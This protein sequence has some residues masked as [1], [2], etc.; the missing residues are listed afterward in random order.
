MPI[1]LETPTIRWSEAE[2]KALEAQEGD[3]W[4]NWAE[5]LK[6]QLRAYPR[7]RKLGALQRETTLA[8]EGRSI[9]FATEDR[10]AVYCIRCYGYPKPIVDDLCR[11]S[12]WRYTG[13]DY[14]VTRLTLKQYGFELEPLPTNQN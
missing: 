14:D 13:S 1:S 6:A 10:R 4:L 12:G 8:N 9:F 3:G 2:N 5:F 7:F 11:R